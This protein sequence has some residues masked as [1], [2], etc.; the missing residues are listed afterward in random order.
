[1]SRESTARIPCET[2]DEPSE[3]HETYPYNTN[4]LHWLRRQIRN[5][6]EFDAEA[7]SHVLL[8]LESIKAMVGEDPRQLPFQLKA[9]KPQ[10]S[11]I[12]W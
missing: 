12:S 9:R 11:P 10:T 5:S 1:M 8:W 4:P 7:K 3:R 6:T 2:S